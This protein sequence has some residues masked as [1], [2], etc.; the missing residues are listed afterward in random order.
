M[1]EADAPHPAT[2]LIEHAR[3]LLALLPGDRAAWPPLRWLIRPSAFDAYRDYLERERI[4]L[5]DV[6][7]PAPT[8][9]GIPYDFGYPS[10]GADLTLMVSAGD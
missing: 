6:A 5:A 3:S 7:A 9:F 4:L 1:T 10:A 8:L 2:H